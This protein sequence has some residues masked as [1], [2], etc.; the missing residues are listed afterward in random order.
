MKGKKKTSMVCDSDAEKRRTR[1]RFQWSFFLR[2]T[3]H[4]RM[5]ILVEVRVEGL[6]TN[7]DVYLSGTL[8]LFE[9]TCSL[10]LL[11]H[12]IE[13][14]Q[15]FR[16]SHTN[17]SLWL[18]ICKEQ[19]NT[20]KHT[21]TWRKDNIKMCPM[22]ARWA[23]QVPD[24]EGNVNDVRQPHDIVEGSIDRNRWSPADLNYEREFGLACT[25]PHTRERTLA[26]VIDDRTSLTSWALPKNSKLAAFRQRSMACRYN[27]LSAVNVTP[28]ISSWV[29]SSSWVL[30][31]LHMIKQCL[32]LL[33]KSLTACLKQNPTSSL[34]NARFDAYRTPTV[35]CNLPDLSVSLESTVMT[36]REREV[37]FIPSETHG[38]AQEVH[39]F[40]VEC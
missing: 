3:L 11:F 30:S 33:F 1:W 19:I 7:L 24:F 36:A 27:S 2:V 21:S 38:W 8:V 9:Q 34:R 10:S 16:H 22:M 39:C 17:A 4:K 18:E 28:F 40:D 31:C 25:D 26:S 32:Y 12:D 15:I 29:K 13:Q 6:K 23:R 37:E 35:G 14:E 20:H 5:Y